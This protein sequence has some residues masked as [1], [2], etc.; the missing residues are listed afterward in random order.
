[1]QVLYH[2]D[3]NHELVHGD[4]ILSGKVMQVPSQACYDLRNS[5]ISLRTSGLDHAVCEVRVETRRLGGDT[6]NSVCLSLIVR[7][8][9]NKVQRLIHTVRHLGGYTRCDV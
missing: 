6:V 8:G 7:R 5:R 9:W 1:M 2:V 4:L 3:A